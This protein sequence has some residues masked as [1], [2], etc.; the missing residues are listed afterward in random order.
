M[1]QK[2]EIIDRL[3]AL[4]RCGGDQQITTSQALT[5]AFDE[6]ARS[7]SRQAIMLSSA[8]IQSG[9]S[10]VKWAQGL[11]EQLPKP[12]DG[13]DSWLLNYGVGEEYD[14]WRSE[15]GV[16]WDE[17]EQCA[18]TR[19]A[20]HVAM[21]P[22]RPGAPSV[23]EMLERLLALGGPEGACAEAALLFHRKGKD[24]NTG[25]GRD[26]YFPLGLP[27]YAQMIWVKALRLISFAKQP[28]GTNF[29]G[30]RDTLLDVISYAAF[31]ADWLK[32]RGKADA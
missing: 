11:V 5:R 10:R 2:K 1:E 6:G 31:A 26:E 3:L 22:A 17:T 7:A 20:E 29:E 8:E 16:A 18:R 9:S 25:V 19:D 13:R 21:I 32:R 30:T 24:Y 14:R 15:Q 27:S 12:H 23:E 28:R 4:T